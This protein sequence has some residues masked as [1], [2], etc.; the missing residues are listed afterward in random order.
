MLAIRGRR[1]EELSVGD[2]VD[3]DVRAGAAALRVPVPAPPRRHGLA[4]ALTLSYS[5]GEGDSAFGAGW[6][7]AGLPAIGINARF[8]VPSWGGSDGYQLDGDELVPWLTEQHG[9]GTPR[10]SNR[11]QWSVAFLRS[12]RGSTRV[13]VENWGAHPT[14]ALISVP[15]T[16]EPW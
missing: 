12:R 8:H 11:S 1:A 4:P 5:S 16:L 14:G 2:A 13:R 10:G 7:L 3:V 9:A 6:R 15:A